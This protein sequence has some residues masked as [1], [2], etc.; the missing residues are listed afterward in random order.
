MAVDGG[1]YQGH[2]GRLLK[3]KSFRQLL[4]ARGGFQ[5]ERVI[6]IITK[7]GN[8][9]AA[10]VPMAFTT[11]VKDKRIQRDDTVLLIGTGA[12]LSAACTLIIY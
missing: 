4:A 1:E 11:A 7:F 10:S 5:K 2:T 6:Q 12:G 9:V 8:C 3:P